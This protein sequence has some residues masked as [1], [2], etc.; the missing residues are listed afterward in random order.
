MVK[1]CGSTPSG[2][3]SSMALSGAYSA[4]IACD[5]PVPF[6]PRKTLIP[7]EKASSASSKTLNCLRC[8]LSTVMAGAG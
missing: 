4:F 6:V 8:K 2:A 7:G 3:L 5:L 1:A